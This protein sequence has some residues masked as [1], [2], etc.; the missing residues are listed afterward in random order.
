MDTIKQVDR[1]RISSTLPRDRI[2]LAQ[3]PQVFRRELL[4]RAYEQAERDG[5]IGT[6]EASLVEHLDVE[7]AVVLGSDRNIK[8][9][10]PSDMALARLFLQEEKEQAAAPAPA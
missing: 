5:F 8:I 4:E 3:T 7:V 6:D 9:T 2:A 1:S 10:R